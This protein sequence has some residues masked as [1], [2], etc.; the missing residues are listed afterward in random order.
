MKKVFFAFPLI[1]LI[2]LGVPYLY[3]FLLT[4]GLFIHLG[5]DI[6]KVHYKLTK[7]EDA[8]GIR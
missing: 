8:K 1:G 7:Y 2:L 4:I 3:P 5:M 6:Y